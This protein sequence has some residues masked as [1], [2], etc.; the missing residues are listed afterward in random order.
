MNFSNVQKIVYLLF[1]LS[2]LLLGNWAQAES[3]LAL[4]IGNGAYHD[5]KQGINDV[6]ALTNPKYDAEDMAELLQ[7][8][9]FTLV[10]DAGRNLPLIDGTKQQ[11][12]AAIDKFLDKL[13]RTPDAVA[14]FYYS[15]HGVYLKDLK[16]PSESANYLLPVG[17]NFRAD[18]PAGIK[19]YAVN[20]H[21]LKDRL[22]NTPV[23]NRLMIFDACRQKLELAESKGFGSGDEFR[24]MDP[25]HGLM[26]VHATLHSYL[27]F[28]N[29]NERNSNFT[30]YLLAALKQQTS[31]Y[32]T[33]AISFGISQVTA[34]NKSISEKY[35]LHPRVEGLL[36]EDFCL[37]DCGSK[38]IPVLPPKI[39]EQ[40]IVQPVPP[41]PPVVN[42]GKTFTNSIGMEFVLIPAG[43]FMMGAN[44]TPDEEEDG[45]KDEKPIHKVNIENPFY[46][47]KTEVTRGQYK[48]V[49][50]ADSTRDDDLLPKGDNLPIIDFNTKE[51]FNR[52][53]TRENTNC[54]R[55]PTEAE[56]EYAAQG[57]IKGKLGDYAWYRNNSNSSLHPVGKKKPNQYGLYD[58]LGNAWEETCSR[59]GSYSDKY[60]TTCDDPHRKHESIWNESI[61]R[62]CSSYSSANECRLTRRSHVGLVEAG[63][64]GFRV[65]FACGAAP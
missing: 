25:E 38:E 12:D 39:P 57:N 52:L 46:M 40:T 54:Y 32:I 23:K 10:D 51:F 3:R 7:N 30:K 61:W 26:V 31:K 15:G 22:Q 65:V 16:R 63:F 14:W 37:A 42:K 27:S 49:M 19:Y 1:V 21:E 50:G 36:S 24:P 13:N 47:G 43:S 6:A 56:W 58:M 5:K 35:H 4:V 60:E 34:A 11:M 29:P 59:V 62:G 2:S 17:H 9:G 48:A 44:F 18:D 33:Q 20:A 41:R 53:N 55:L 28:G 45:G 8:S 64:S